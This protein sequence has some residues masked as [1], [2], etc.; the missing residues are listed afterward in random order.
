M[1]FYREASL[2][3]TVSSSAAQRGTSTGDLNGCLHSIYIA[4]SKPFNTSAKVHIVAAETTRKVLFTMKDPSTNGA[5]YFPRRTVVGTTNNAYT[6]SGGGLPGVALNNERFKT[7]I[8]TASSNSHGG[9][10][11]VTVGVI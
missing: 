1:T 9:V 2:S 4:A 11:T 5:F 6:S 7:I 3:V 8:S 10:V